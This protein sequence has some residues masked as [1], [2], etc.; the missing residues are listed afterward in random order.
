MSKNV[1]MIR[2]RTSNN[3]SVE[4]VEARPS[5]SNAVEF[6]Y[7]IIIN[8][9]KVGDITIDGVRHTTVEIIDMYQAEQTALASIE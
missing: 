6:L 1:I 7:H 5:M 8:T 4:K 9:T 2:Y 3:W